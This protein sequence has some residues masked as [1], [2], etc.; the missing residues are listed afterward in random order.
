M[1]Y[2]GSLRVWEIGTWKEVYSGQL[3]KSV[4]FSVTFTPDGKALVTG[5]EN[6]GYTVKVTPMVGGPPP[7]HMIMTLLL[8]RRNSWAGS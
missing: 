6:P 8:L 2:G 1:G 3:P 5:H 7:I 4:V